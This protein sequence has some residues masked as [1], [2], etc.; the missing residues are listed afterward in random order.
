MTRI[1]H[2]RVL[3]YP[4]DHVWPAAIR[5]LRVDRK[6]SLVDRDREAG[7]ILF[8]FPVGTNP[9]GPSGRGSLELVTTKD[10]SG[11]PSVKL[12]VS[13]DAGPTH[14]PHAIADGVASK[15]REE[16]GQPAPP[17]RTEPPT[18]PKPPVEDDGPWANQPP[19]SGL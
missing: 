12:N 2:S 4:A 14:L 1:Q 15:L 18:P 6:Y 7:F 8:D 11:R 19:D 5:Y 9:D 16:R 13:T 17:P 3:S 10:A